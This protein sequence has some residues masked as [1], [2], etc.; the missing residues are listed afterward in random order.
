MPTL[1]DPQAVLSD[2]IRTVVVPRLC[3]AFDSSR[4]PRATPDRSPASR[5]PSGAARGVSASAAELTRLLR[6]AELDA[7]QRLACRALCFCGSL[8]VLA[9]T[10]FE[11]TARCL[12]DLWQNDDCSDIDVSLA[13]VQLQAILH[14]VGRRVPRQALR[15]TAPSVLVVPLPGETHQLGAAIDAEMLWHAGWSPQLEFPATGDAL[16]RLLGRRWVDALDVSL[17]TSFRRE[18]RLPQLGEMIRR[19]R[20][21][22][23]NPRL[24]V[25]VSGRAFDDTWLGETGSRTDVGADASFAS[26]AQAESTIRGALGRP[27][28]TANA[29]R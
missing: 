27:V 23:C 11:P 9:A 13:L 14:E 22:S 1:A 20:R 7:A 16:D 15:E 21:A 18:H 26:A 28:E 3:A 2:L 5:P 4:R 25:V 6:A 8:G 19:A 10:L 12:G 17:S 29:R 24:V